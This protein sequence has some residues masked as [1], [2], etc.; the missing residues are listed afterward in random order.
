L[1]RENQVWATDDSPLIEEDGKLIKGVKWAIFKGTVWLKGHTASVDFGK[2]KIASSA[3]AVGGGDNDG[4]DGEVGSAG[5][6]HYDPADFP[7]RYGFYS[8]KSILLT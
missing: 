7:E 2:L 1:Y 3:P 8:S 4:G 5:G 6:F